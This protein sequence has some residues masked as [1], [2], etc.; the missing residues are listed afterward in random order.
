MMD[1]RMDPK[2][3]KNPQLWQAYLFWEEMARPQTKH[4]QRIKSIEAG[5]SNLDAQFERDVMEMQQPLIISAQEMMAQYGSLIPVWD[6]MVGIK[7]IGDLTAAKILA[8][9]DDVGKYRTISKFWRVGGQGLYKYWID[10]R[11]VIQ[12][13][14]DGYK[15]R[16]AKAGEWIKNG[17]ICEECTPGAVLVKKRG[18][19]EPGQV[20]REH[21][22]VVPEP[23]WRLEDRADVR[24]KGWNSPYNKDLKRE[25]WLLERSFIWQQTPYYVDLYYEEK[26]RLRT[27]HP[28]KIKINGRWKYNDGHLNNMAKRKMCKRFLADLW[29]KWRESEGLPVSRPYVI[30][31]LGHTGYIEPMRELE[32]G[33]GR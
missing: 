22:V 3:R 19:I 4:K 6:W 16:K 30:E 24:L 10:E 15:S 20:I 21:I 14:K 2:P 33:G 13:P 8:L 32:R 1:K 27:V 18:D 28:E 23:G 26:T 31:I 9:Y 17:T 5:K 29:V 12:A 7:G 11:G 25:I